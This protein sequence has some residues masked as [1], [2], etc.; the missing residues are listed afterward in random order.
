ML[1]EPIKQEIRDIMTRISQAL[2]GYKSRPAQRIMIAEVAKIL[3]TAPAGDEAKHSADQGLG[4]LQFGTG[5]GKSIAYLAAGLVLAKHKQKTLVISTSTVA[6]QEQLMFRDI[7]FFLNAAGISGQP[8]LA[9]GRSRYVCNLRLERAARHNAQSALFGEDGAASQ[10]LSADEQ[11]RIVTLHQDFQNGRWGGDR[12]ALDNVPDS[13]WQHITTDSAGC[14]N[15]NC[16]HVRQCAQL[17]ARKRV[18]DSA[19]I[20]ANHDLVLADLAMGGGMVLPAPSQCIYIFDEGDTLPAKAVDSF[21][22]HHLVGASL[23]VMNRLASAQPDLVNALGSAFEASAGQICDRAE[24][25]AN[26][27]QHLNTFFGHL[28]ALKPTGSHAPCLDFEDATLPEGLH[29]LGETI[30]RQCGPLQADLQALYE[31][32]SL[33][34]GDHPDERSAKMLSDMLLYLGQ[35]DNL[36]GTWE[37]LLS[38][39]ANLVEPPVAKWVSFEAQGRRGDFMLHASPIIAA[40]RL[41]RDL[42]AKAAGAIVTSATLTA[43]GEFDDFMLR[44][45]LDAYNVPCLDLPSPFDYATQGS[46]DIPRMPSP[47]DYEAHT[48]EVTAHLAGLL[49]QMGPEGMLVIFTSRRQLEDVAGRLPTEL[50]SRILL[51]GTKSK[52]QLIDDHRAAI[53]AGRP[54]A[55]F[56]LDSFSTGVDLPGTYCTTVVIPRLPFAVPDSPVGSALGRWIKARGG[57]A[58]T[59]IAVPEAGRKLQ[60]IV[61]RLIRT[62]T[63]SGR[64]VCLDPRLWQASYGRSILNGLPPFRVRAMGGRP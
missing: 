14:L 27:L 5:T 3:A 58:F 20:V 49:G 53:D 22:S 23:R 11:D 54:S 7:P 28:S 39:P 41:R 60:Q 45:G 63:D 44:S 48:R 17:T 19:L 55:I 56:G 32:L 33:S 51:Q 13:L 59:E 25:V 21:A 62:E 34:T 38:E 8:E 64:I 2:P 37:L 50:K 31:A 1:T 29:E 42:W 36:L 35:V 24:S 12:D 9:K 46:I 26:A 43:L 15:R 57:D 18:K 61:G 47:K 4:V 16:P 6:L 30:V 40:Q 52:G 10:S